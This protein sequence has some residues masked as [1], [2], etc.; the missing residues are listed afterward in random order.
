MKRFKFVFDV[1]SINGL[2]M[3]ALVEELLSELSSPPR[4]ILS[5]WG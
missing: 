2:Q 4:G 1:G 5:A 3:L